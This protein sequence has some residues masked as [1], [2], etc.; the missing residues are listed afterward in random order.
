MLIYKGSERRIKARAEII[1]KI[2]IC[3]DDKD[4]CA[5]LRHWLGR[6]RCHCVIVHECKSCLEKVKKEFFK[7]VLLDNVFADGKGV[8]IIADI[9]TASPATK[10]LV[11]TGYGITEDKLVALNYGAGYLEKPI[12]FKSLMTKLNLVLSE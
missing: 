2:L 7:V 1:S 4:F 12:N 6:I 8:D 11:V 10:I 3:D 9:R 5:V